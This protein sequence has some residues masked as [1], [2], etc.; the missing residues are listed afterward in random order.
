MRRPERRSASG[1][2]GSAGTGRR[3][4]SMRPRRSR[5]SPPRPSPL[6]G[7]VLV[8]HRCRRRRPTSLQT[9]P[10]RAGRRRLGRLRPAP[11]SYPARSMMV[12]EASAARSSQKS[13]S[14][15]VS[16]SS[17]ASMR[18]PSSLGV[19]EPVDVGVSA[20]LPAAGGGCITTGAAQL[21]LARRLIAAQRCRRACPA[22]V[23]HR[24]LLR[25]VDRHCRT[26]HVVSSRRLAATPP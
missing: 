22:L 11:A 5:R 14:R 26:A 20:R 7:R 12:T 18:R 19:A 3:G 23:P 15:L 6:K 10:Q 4:A 21:W 25:P 9:R 13:G 17:A 8:R 2:D 16:V 1:A 24:P